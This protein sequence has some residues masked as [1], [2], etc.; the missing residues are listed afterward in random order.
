MLVMFVAATVAQ[1]APPPIDCRQ[2]PASAR[3]ALDFIRRRDPATA[4]RLTTELRPWLAGAAAGTDPTVDAAATELKTMFDG[5]RGMWGG[6]P[7]FASAAR[8]A[9]LARRCLPAR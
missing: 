3:T 5:H 2:A 6:E 8:A 4:D 7:D 9:A 1:A